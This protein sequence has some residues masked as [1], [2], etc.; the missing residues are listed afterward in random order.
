[1]AAELKSGVPKPTQEM[2]R[3]RWYGSDEIE[4]ISPIGGNYKNML[5][6][7]RLS[8]NAVNEMSVT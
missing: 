4:K 5:Q 8:L 7:W 3:Y 2:M 1:V 6:H